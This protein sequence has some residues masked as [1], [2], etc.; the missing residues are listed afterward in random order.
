MAQI[1]QP[2]L[3]MG[4]ANHNKLPPARKNK[5][6]VGAA[7]GLRTCTNVPTMEASLGPKPP[8]QVQPEWQH[9][10]TS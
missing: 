1:A 7:R 4:W 5:S 8:V 3:D 10:L 2:W 9:Q 6:N